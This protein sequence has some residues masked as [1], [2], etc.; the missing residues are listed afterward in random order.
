MAK[1]MFTVTFDLPER[2]MLEELTIID[3]R[4]KADIVRGLIR[5]YHMDRAKS[6]EA[7]AYR[8]ALAQIQNGVGGHE[9]A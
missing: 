2:I 1:K 4:S 5:K 8:T 9:Q 6:P 3:G 7:Q